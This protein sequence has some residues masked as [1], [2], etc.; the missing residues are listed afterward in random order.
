VSL[1]SSELLLFY[2]FFTAENS[3][4][5]PGSKSIGTAFHI[6]IMLLA[7]CRE[8]LAK[9]RNTAY[10][11]ILEQ[12][13]ETQTTKKSSSI[14]ISPLSNWDCLSQRQMHFNDE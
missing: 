11:I 8:I 2:L 1:T 3:G 9:I 4:V 12:K 13:S 7:I 6:C 14:A 5:L 10:S